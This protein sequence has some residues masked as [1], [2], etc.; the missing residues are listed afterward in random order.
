M[1]WLFARGDGFDLVRLV[2]SGASLAGGLAY[3][4]FT[5]QPPTPPRAALKAVGFGL[6]TPVPLTFLGSAPGAETGLIVL[7]LALAL[8]T[9]G[10]I[11]LALRNQEQFFVFGL[12]AFLCAHLAYLAVLLPLVSV[13]GILPALSA[14]ALLVAAGAM[15]AWLW[16]GLG[17]MRVPVTAYFAVIT[18]MT[19]AAI[20]ARGVPALGAVGAVLFLLSDSLIGVRKF[21]APFPLV[22]EAIWATY[23]AGQALLAG[24]ILYALV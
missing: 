6:L 16:P 23:Y 11:L 21:K 19:V 22:S 1:E 13:P 17:K 5:A 8:S 3:F 2:L 10:D 12:G 4:A 9:A 18:A 24:G 7:A 20:L 14:V 15:M